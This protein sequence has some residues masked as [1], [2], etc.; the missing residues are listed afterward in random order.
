MEKKLLIERTS[1]ELLLK[2]LNVSDNDKLLE[3]V[4][5]FT[6]STQ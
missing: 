2:A 1:I 4:K 6:L 5:Y 3:G